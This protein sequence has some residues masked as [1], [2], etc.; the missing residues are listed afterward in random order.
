MKRNLVVLGELGELCGDY[1]FFLSGWKGL[2]FKLFGG[3]R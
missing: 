1:F 3:F 2:Y